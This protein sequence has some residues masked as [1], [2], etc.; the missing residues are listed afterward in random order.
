[1]KWL[2]DQAI[3]AIRL[4]LNGLIITL[5]LDHVFP[6]ALLL[7]KFTLW[8]VRLWW[9]T[10]GTAYRQSCQTWLIKHDKG[11]DCVFPP[12]SIWFGNKGSVFPAAP[13]PP[14]FHSRSVLPF[15]SEKHCF[16]SGGHG[17]R[18]CFLFSHPKSVYFLPSV[19]EKAAQGWRQNGSSLSQSRSPERATPALAC[20]SVY[21]FG[22]LRFP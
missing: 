9:T 5:R 14:W 2:L 13:R 1:M 15:L 6:A 21:C 12:E 11:D 10:H 16:I 3:Q 17:A 8:H 19:T 20:Q 4:R 22:F 7:H 18:T